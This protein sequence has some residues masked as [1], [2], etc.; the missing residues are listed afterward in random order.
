MKLHLLIPSLFWPEDS[1]PEIY[2]DLPLP[3]LETLLAKSLRT[4]DESNGLEA[5]L[6]RTFGVE[7]QQDWPVAPITLQADSGGQVTAGNHY[8]LR[9]DP[10]HLR[11]E[12]TQIVLADSQI[13]RVTAEEAIQF[14]DLLNRHFAGD[15][16]DLT[17]GDS[18]ITKQRPLLLPLAP[19]RW[20]LRVTEAPT[21]KTHSLSS[22]S[23]RDISDLLPSGGDG[24]QWQRYF[25]EIQMFLYEHPLN[26]AREARGEL[27]INSIWPWGGGTMP[28]SIGSPYTHVWGNA[29]LPK[30]LALATT[31]SHAD[32]PPTAAAWHHAAATGNHLVI[33][34][35]LSGKAQYDDAYGWRENL[36]KFELEWF[37]P[38]LKS[39][40]QG[41][42]EKLTLTT[43]DER[44]IKSFSITSYDLWKFWRAA[45]PLAT[46]AP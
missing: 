24:L 34:D 40:K 42:L 19:D 29:V 25:N 1:L 39:L 2:R 44:S 10:V 21:L 14:T 38:L 9:A 26:L 41:E 15:G 36:N 28:Q 30:S 43:V 3:A 23:G 18:G 13:F 4:E 12:H 5:W 27:A 22:V 32:L 7:K 37:G 33:L 16:Y 46:Y 6:C 35:T 20:Y 17:L 8:W 31:T 45:K 11:I